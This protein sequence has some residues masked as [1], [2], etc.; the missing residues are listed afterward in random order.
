[1]RFDDSLAT[2]ALNLAD[3]ADIHD[4]AGIVAIYRS[5]VREG[6][7]ATELEQELLSYVAAKRL[8]GR[9]ELC[10]HSSCND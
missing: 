5:V 7:D 8:K 10:L 4:V 2:D 9:Q 3:G 6:L 1:M